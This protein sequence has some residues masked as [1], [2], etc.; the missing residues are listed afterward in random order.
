MR[1][2]SYNVFI[3]SRLLKEKHF[4]IEEE[5]RGR[6]E[7]KLKAEHE[8]RNNRIKRLACK[9]IC[10]RIYSFALI[11]AI[12]LYLNSERELSLVLIALINSL[13]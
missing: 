3:A 13:V 9:S 4:R 1:N 11:F 6:S 8:N 10:E 7:E 12:T 5:A 2:N